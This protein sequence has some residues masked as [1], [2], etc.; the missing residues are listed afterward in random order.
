MAT[1]TERIDRLKKEL[2]EAMHDERYKN[3]ASVPDDS[4]T[5]SGR[6]YLRRHND[7]IGRLSHELDLHVR[8]RRIIE[9][10]VFTLD[11][12]NQCRTEIMN[13]FPQYEHPI[14][15]GSGILFAA[16]AIRKSFGTKF[17]LILYRYPIKIDFG[18]S[19]R[20]ICIIHPSN[21]IEYRKKQEK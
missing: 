14:D 2:D 1:I 10:E 5:K 12:I 3:L 4:Q 19:H 9:G 16:E 13:R 8:I 20:R 7:R 15:A 18:T 6:D 17:T 21:F 11:D